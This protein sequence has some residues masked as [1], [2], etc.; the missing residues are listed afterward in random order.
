MKYNRLSDDV[1]IALGLEL[2]SK[3]KGGNPKYALTPEQQ[4]Q[5]KE[6]KN[7]GLLNHCKNRG[8]DFT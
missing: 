8:I 1:A 7:N 6:I 2:M 4:L 3:K 5:L